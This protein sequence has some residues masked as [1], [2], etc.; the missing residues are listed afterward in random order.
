[1]E[2]GQRYLAQGERGKSDGRRRA[3][4]R[5]GGAAR[6]ARPKIKRER[7][8]ESAE[9]GA[10]AIERAHAGAESVVRR[11]SFRSD[12]STARSN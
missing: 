7:R 1:M 11:L 6:A 9:G 10:T 4:L 12:P 8:G 5:E 2:G 3:R